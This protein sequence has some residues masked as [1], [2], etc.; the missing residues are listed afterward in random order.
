M[1]YT[2]IIYILFVYAYHIYKY[3]SFTYCVPAK[4]QNDQATNTP[5]EPISHFPREHLATRPRSFCCLAAQQL[6]GTTGSSTGGATCPGTLRHSGGESL[7]TTGDQ[8]AARFG[9]RI[10][11]LAQ[12]GMFGWSLYTS[13]CS[14]LLRIHGHQSLTTWCLFSI[15]FFFGQLDG[16]LPGSACDFVLFPRL[17]QKTSQ[18]LL[19]RTME[20]VSFALPPRVEVEGLVWGQWGPT[21]ERLMTERCHLD[22]P[23]LANLKKYMKSSTH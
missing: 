3:I 21:C 18:F 12:V 23:I 11:T 2:I 4:Q 8:G 5:G 6:H 22:L 17:E 16:I 20:N 14:N 7:R 15:A 1:C 10:P 13:Y 9:K 19:R